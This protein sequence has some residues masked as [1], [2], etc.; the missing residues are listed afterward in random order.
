MGTSAINLLIE[1]IKADLALF[2]QLNPMYILTIP[3]LCRHL[4]KYEEQNRE[5]K[6]DEDTDLIF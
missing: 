2:N 4:S 5:K 6:K 1:C 3:D